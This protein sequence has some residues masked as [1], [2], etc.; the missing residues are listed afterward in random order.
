MPCTQIL[1]YIL[2]LNQS[3]YFVFD[4]ATAVGQVGRKGNIFYPG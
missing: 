1:P 3:A 2:Q 4:T